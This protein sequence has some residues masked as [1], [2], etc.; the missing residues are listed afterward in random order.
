MKS[1]SIEFLDLDLLPTLPALA[2]EERGG[3]GL[4][5]RHRGSLVRND[6]DRQARVTLLAQ[7]ALRIIRRVLAPLVPICIGQPG[8]ILDDWV[9]DL[10]AQKTCKDCIILKSASQYSS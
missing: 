1:E 7:P 4:A 5:E 6:V 3:D 2:P 10:N 9:V 8:E